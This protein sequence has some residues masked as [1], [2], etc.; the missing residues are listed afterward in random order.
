M[1]CRIRK[2]KKGKKI[3]EKMHQ[4]EHVNGDTNARSLLVKRH[5][6]SANG[7]V[8]SP[9]QTADNRKTNTTKKERKREKKKE[10]KGEKDRN[11]IV[12]FVCVCFRLEKKICDTPEIKDRK[13][14]ASRER[15]R[16]KK[17]HYTTHRIKIINV[18]YNYVSTRLFTC[19]YKG[20]LV[21]LYLCN[22]VHV[23]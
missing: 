6:R 9:E 4:L 1:C 2:K 17:K 18:F 5:K 3:F 10:K 12:F 23:I 21:Y 15:E 16:E 8:G 11:N 7:S 14:K 22:Y 19:V 13:K 20:E